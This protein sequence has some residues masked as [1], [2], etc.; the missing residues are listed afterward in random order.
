MPAAASPSRTASGRACHHAW[1]TNT[2]STYS[3]AKQAR[4]IAVF[5]Y[6]CGQSRCRR[7]VRAEV[8][9]DPPAHL[10]LEGLI[11]PELQRWCCQHS[12]SWCSSTF[13]NAAP[14]IKKIGPF[15]DGAPPTYREVGCSHRKVVSSCPR[16]RPGPAA[17]IY[18]M[19]PTVK[20]AMNRS[21]KKL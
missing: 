13:A 4:R 19:A 5:R 12:S 16:R 11:G 20:P 21:T 3:A 17:A 14:N 7:P 15:R 9:V 10:E 8:L 1:A 2:S 18:L 6:I